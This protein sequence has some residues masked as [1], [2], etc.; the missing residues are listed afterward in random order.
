MLKKKFIKSKP[1][2][3]VTFQLP[4]DIEAKKVS[5]VGEFNDWN[6]EVNH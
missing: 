3:Q 1:I 2:C 5:L 4:Q 6:P